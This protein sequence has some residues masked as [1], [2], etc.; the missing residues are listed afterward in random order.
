MNPNGGEEINM[1][2]HKIERCL[3][4]DFLDL[5]E[6]L[7]EDIKGYVSFHNDTIIEYSSEFYPDSGEFWSDQ[8]SKATLEQ[9]AGSET[10]FDVWLVEQG[11]DLDVHKILINV[12]W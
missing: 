9:Y 11:F 7:Q 8:L 12:C 2:R 4:L 3:I 1:I 10:P 5:P 6:E